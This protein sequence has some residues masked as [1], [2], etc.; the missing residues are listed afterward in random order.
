MSNQTIYI[1]G[2]P[3]LEIDSLPI[4]LLPDLQKLYPHISFIL[5]DPNEE[6]DIP[7]EMVVID[8]ALGLDKITVFN[9][10]DSFHSGPHLSMHDF[11]A[12][13]NLRYMKKLGKLKKIKIIGIP[14][15]IEKDVALEEIGKIIKNLK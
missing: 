6:W 10:L 1:F 15:E 5:K 2:N 13:T 14:P 12:L 9:D 11:D 7:P 3:D 4:K 8:T